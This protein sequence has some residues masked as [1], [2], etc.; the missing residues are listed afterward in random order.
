MY[1]STQ[2]PLRQI[3]LLP[4]NGNW[5]GNCDIFQMKPIR[6]TLLL[7]I[8]ISTSLHVTGD[9]VPIIRRNNC[10][11]IY[12]T[13]GTCYSVWVTVW[14]AGAYAPAYQTATHT[15][16]KIPVSHRYSLHVSGNYVPIIRRT[17]CIYATLV[18][19]TLYVWPSGMREHMLLQTRQSS[20]QNNK[21]QVSYKYK[22]SCFSWWWA[23]SHLKHVQ[24][25]K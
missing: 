7:N 6:C 5:F 22:Y 23:H 25:L 2:F 16:W 1:N 9:H 18:F 4:I 15:K 24:K 13:L 10:I 12:T 17:Y 3:L 14:F 11:Y 20:I 19:F 8:F 21:Y